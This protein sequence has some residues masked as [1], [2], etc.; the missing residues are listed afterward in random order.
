MPVGEPQAVTQGADMRS[1]A[2]S[3]D[4]TR[5]A[6][7]RGGRVSNI[8]RVPILTDRPATW[9]DAHAV[10]SESAFIEFVDVSPD[11]ERLALSS[12]RRGNQDLWILPSAGGEMTPLMRDPTPDWNP[13]WS[14]DGTAIAF[15]TYR[16]GNRDL[17][18]MPSRGGAPRQLTSHP[19]R[20]WYPSWSPDGREIAFARGFGGGRSEIWIVPA[21]GGEARVLGPGVS[22][23]WAPNGTWIAVQNDGEL[24]RVPL[25]GSRP[26]LLLP[27]G[28]EPSILRFSPDGQWLYFSVITG[29]Q[30]NQGIWQLSW[31]DA[32]LSRA[33][34]LQGRRGR[35]GYYF[36]VDARYLYFAWR[37]DAGDIW[38]MDVAR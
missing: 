9:A 17:W 35:V 20:D 16:T 5:L 33:T 24:Y 18:V 29:P 26:Q 6:Y 12:D 25:D 22:A 7:S 30:E 34:A 32:K 38:V 2:F 31:P 36:T 11:G 13:R 21:T 4:G 8:W 10:T 3:R 19:A 15:Y 37:E 28:K 23:D 27:K 14:R 1:A